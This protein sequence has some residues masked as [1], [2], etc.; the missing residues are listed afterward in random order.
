[1]DTLYGQDRVVMLDLVVHILPARVWR[2]LVPSDVIMFLQQH[3]VLF[4][5]PPSFCPLS[6]LNVILFVNLL[7]SLGLVFSAMKMETVFLSS[8]SK[9]SAERPSHS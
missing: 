1:M 3:A 9:A 2:I 4:P 6:L 5:T 8:M 7:Q